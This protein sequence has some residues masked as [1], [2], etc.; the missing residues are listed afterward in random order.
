MNLITPKEEIGRR[1][2]SLRKRLAREELDGAL[3]VQAVD[4]YYYSGTR[5]NGVLWIPSE[6][7][8]VLLVRKSF[9]RAKQES[10]IEDI[11]TFPPSREMPDVL[12][13]QARRIGLTLDVL[14]VQ[15]FNFYRGL[16]PGRDFL[17]ISVLCRECRSVKSAWELEQMRMSGRMLAEAF[18]RIPDFLVP[19]MRELDFAA[20]FEYR[21]R[22]SG[23]GGFLRIRGF[24]QEL[25][26]IAASGENGAASGCFDGAVTGAGIWTAAP[27]GPS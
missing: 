3:F 26:G 4:V 12:G 16:L 15:Y 17:D 2:D 6:G 23:V 7:S 14:P 22:K 21:L 9:S 8:P 5:Q 25:T 18:G 10:S 19:G 11:R 1:I 24:N 27:Y 20:E 13:A